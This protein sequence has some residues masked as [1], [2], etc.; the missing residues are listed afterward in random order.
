MGKAMAAAVLAMVIAATPGNTAA[1]E[2]AGA[3]RPEDASVRGLIARGAERSGT[4]RDLIARLDATDVVVYVRFSA[5]VGRVPACLLWASTGPGVRR[6]LI[7]V[8]RYAGSEDTLTALFAHE[9]QHASEV[10][11]APGIV[12]LSSFERIFNQR[13]LKSSYGFE[14]TEARDVTRTVLRELSSSH[15]AARP[16]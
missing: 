15:A 1:A 4:L 2:A 12:D 6:V 13:A 9:L 5:C 10:A 16:K 11:A 8:D 7:K 14:T 3:V